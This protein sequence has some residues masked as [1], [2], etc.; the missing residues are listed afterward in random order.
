MQIQN[1]VFVRTIPS[2]ATKLLHHVSAARY[3]MQKIYLYYNED[4]VVIIVNDYYFGFDDLVSARLVSV[5]RWLYFHIDWCIA[6]V[7][8]TD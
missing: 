8:C 5:V 1:P 4:Y 3:F 6:D 2:T 7:K